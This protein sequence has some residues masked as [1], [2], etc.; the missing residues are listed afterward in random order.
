MP[1]DPLSPPSDTSMPAGPSGAAP[2]SGPGRMLCF[3][4]YA[5][6]LA[7][8]RVYKPLLD[9]LGLTYP[10]YLVMVTLWGAEGPLSVKS[11]GQ[12]LSLDSGTLTPLLKRLDAAGLVTRMRN[13]D[14][15]RGTLISLTASGRQ[16]QERAR[17]V[18][19]AIRKATGLGM[20]DL[21]RLRREI[22]GLRDRLVGM[23]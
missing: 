10:Q 17:H 9:P 12:T 23:E 21:E 11:I 13:P 18:P 22:T 7:F 16:M 6:N 4:I 14:D 19:E 1:A 5:T 15:E 3:D 2:G 20:E 8:G